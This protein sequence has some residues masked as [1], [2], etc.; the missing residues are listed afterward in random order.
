MIQCPGCDELHILDHRWTFNND[1]ERPTFKPSLLCRT[2]DTRCHSFITA[3]R[4]RFLADC[5]H[6]LAGQT[7]DLPEI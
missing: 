2:D 7:V 3:G 5:T 4:I 1:P 6:A